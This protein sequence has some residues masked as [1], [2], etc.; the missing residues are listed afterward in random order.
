MK[1]KNDTLI[2]EVTKQIEELQV[3]QTDLLSQ[4]HT[5]IQQGCTEEK[6]FNTNNRVQIQVNGATLAGYIAKITKRRVHIKVDNSPYVLR[7]P[8]NAIRIHNEQS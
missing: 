8:K 4:L 5:L 3:T 2:K 7:A 1:N 6:Q